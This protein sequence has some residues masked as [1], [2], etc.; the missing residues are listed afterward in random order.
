[1]A[2]HQRPHHK[3]K[4]TCESGIAAGV[5]KP[6]STFYVVTPLPSEPIAAMVA[7][8]KTSFTA[9]GGIAGIGNSQTITD[10]GHVM[11]PYISSK[12][13]DIFESANS[14][15]AQNNAMYGSNIEYPLVGEDLLPSNHTRQ[16]TAISS[17]PSSL[18]AATMKISSATTEVYHK[19]DDKRA[20]QEQMAGMTLNKTVNSSMQQKVS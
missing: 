20:M 8:S 5:E 19:N 3:L 14:A 1:M 7:S 17:N 16:L 10:G 18:V 9:V 13:Y 11:C 12:P 15:A 6:K 2:N 4:G